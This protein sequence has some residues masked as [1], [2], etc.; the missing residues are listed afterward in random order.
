M[1]RL[2]ATALL[3][4]ATTASA[5]QPTPRE[6]RNIHYITADTVNSALDLYQSTSASPAPVLIYFHGGSWT[7]GARPKS[8]NSFRG[9]LDLGF[10]VLSVDYRMSGVAPAPA[11][12]QDAR[13]VLAWVKRNATQYDLDTN[14]IVTYG[15]SAGGQLAL[16]AAMLPAKSAVDT[17]ACADLPHVAAVLDYYRPTDVG[18]FARK[19]ANTRKWLADSTR[20]DEIGRAMSP[21]IYVRAG[22]PPVLIVHGDSDPTVPHEQSERLRDALAAVGVPVRMYT[23]PGGLHGNFSA[24][25]KEIVMKESA[26]FLRE[27]GVIH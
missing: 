10:S 19:S 25:Q 27:R 22:L 7:T 6:V 14:R 24:E 18:A 12:V 15:T 13:C 8:A 26:A 9:F 23:V 4:I 16:M 20:F 21:L 11:A 17:P 5:Q 2:I 1:S 3:A